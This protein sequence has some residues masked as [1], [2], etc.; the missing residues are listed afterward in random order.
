MKLTMADVL[1]RDIDLLIIRSF[2][3]NESFRSRLLSKIGIAGHVT[4]L[5]AFHSLSDTDGESDITFII[6]HN[7]RKMGILIENKI[8]AIAQPNQ[9]FRY[10]VR[11]NSSV[12]AHA[13]DE[14]KIL[15]LAPAKYLSDNSEAKNYETQISYEYIQGLFDKGCF[16][17]QMLE[18][19]INKE[20]TGY[21][22]K[23]VKEITLFWDEMYDH[24]EKNYPR[25]LFNGIK[26]APKGPRCHWFSFKTNVKKTTIQYKADRKYI[27]LELAG[28]GDCY[29]E[30]LAANPL[31]FTNFPEIT[32]IRTAGKSLAVEIQT[33]QE[34][35]C[36]GD[37]TSQIEIINDALD[38]VQLLQEIVLP[39]LVLDINPN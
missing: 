35:D 10:T 1:E 34:L 39:T 25:L 32:R 4:V 37:F 29:A 26:G 20:G 24:I 33:S 30:F 2:I 38:K 8:N 5:N 21:E 36:R 11:G 13:Y 31:L 14:Y 3:E 19:A 22:P 9:A 6:E 23:E 7:R 15:I 16:E 28:L 27:D 12:A 18:Q 17:Y